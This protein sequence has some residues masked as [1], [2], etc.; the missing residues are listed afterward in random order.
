MKKILPLLLFLAIIHAC[1]QSQADKISGGKGTLTDEKIQNYIKAYK[2]LKDGVPKMLEK[3]NLE[4]REMSPGEIGFS[5]IEKMIQDAGLKDYPEFVRLNAKIGAVFSILQAK[6]GMKNFKNLEESSS[7]MIDDGMKIVQDQ[8]NNPDVPE[9]TKMALRQQ[10]NE[11]KKN[12]KQLHSEYNH[13]FKWANVVMDKVQ[14]LTDL[15]V[16]ENDVLLVKKY[17][18]EIMHAYV[19]FPLPA[20]MNG[21]LPKLNWELEEF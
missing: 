12:Q 5:N 1:S 10:L 8:I 20:E 11:M 16:N 14:D 17:E 9:E 6:K 15:I 21:K 13:N 18:D 19:G 4:S 3:L 2:A 7:E